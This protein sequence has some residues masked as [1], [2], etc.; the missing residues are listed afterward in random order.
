MNYESLLLLKSFLLNEVSI[1][2]ENLEN[3]KLKLC[4]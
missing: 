2:A 4:K 3:Y 1:N